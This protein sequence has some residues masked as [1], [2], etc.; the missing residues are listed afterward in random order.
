MVD[1]QLVEHRRMDVVRMDRI[2]DRFKAEIVRRAV[3]YAAS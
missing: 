3:G 2:F 1:A